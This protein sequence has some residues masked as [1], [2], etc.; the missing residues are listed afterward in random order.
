MTKL[1][2]PFTTETA[3]IPR[4]TR[5]RRDLLAGLTVASV[6]VPQSMAYALVA[7]I[8]P[9]YGLYSAIVVTLLGAVIPGTSPQLING[10]TNA[11][12]LVVFSAIASLN[13]P[14]NAN[15]IHAV[16]LLAMLVGFI[17]LLLG[18]F[19]LG[20]LTRYV[21]ESVILGFMAGAGVLI[22][23][24]QMPHL[25]GLTGKGGGHSYFLYRLWLTLTDVNA[26]I[27]W[28]AI[29]TGL[30]T[31]FLVVLLRGA[32]Q[33]WR[34]EIPDLLPALLGA[35][36]LVWALDWQIPMTGDVPS[37][38]PT[39]HLPR[40]AHLDW[41]PELTG[42]AFAIALLGLLEA[43]AIAK[44]ISARTG[45][46]LDYN[47]QCFAEGVSNLGGGLFQ[48]MPGSGSLTRSAINFQAG[49]VTRWS[50][51]ISAITVAVVVLLL[52]D[53][54]KYVPKAGLAGI[55]L[56]ASWRLVDRARLK[57]SLRASRFDTG[58]V[59][60]TGLSA[61]FLSVEL[62]ILIGTFLSFL[63]I[64]P[65]AARLQATELV[66]SGERTV[67]ERRP[68]DPSCS[69]MVILS[70]E[71]E[72]FFG[73]AP[74]LESHLKLLEDRV[75]TGAQVVVLRVK[76]ARHPDMVCMEIVQRFLQ[77]M[78]TRGIPVLICG[79]RDDWMET[80]DRLH[81]HSW[82]PRDWVFREDPNIESSTLRAV[83]R[84]YELL[85]EDLCETCPRRQK[86]DRPEEDWYYVI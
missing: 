36:L 65:R 62:S 84:A 1:G 44:S 79:A 7:G 32:R 58:L 2:I 51:I 34:V 61:I 15:P 26:S 56:V 14:A 50:G 37:T 23:L 82:L 71:G 3:P 21:S 53:Y 76:R 54:A 12:S 4:W 59:M 46:Q 48:C 31:M 20:D 80:M 39:P 49:A 68:E 55:L 86:T 13:L 43:I 5:I 45:H 57:Y 38:L 83:K 9:K 35:S 77:K 25:L 70:L 85:Q 24:G 42:S 28:Q 17:Q 6:A 16:F 10:P 67:R 60:T 8:D 29:A 30:L 11:I 69:R 78:I 74:E 66:L 47:R 52:A 63:L 81:F 19:R 64:V 75:E 18:L 27:L 40:L 73:A 72:L 41:V 33:R 22:A